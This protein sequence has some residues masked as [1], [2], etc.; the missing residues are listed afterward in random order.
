MGRKEKEFEELDSAVSI[1][2]ITKCPSKWLL[3][4]RETGSVYQG[5]PHGYW[6]RL[7]PVTRKTNGENLNG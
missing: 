7:D 1:P 3:V 6:D 2:V 5:T 4:D